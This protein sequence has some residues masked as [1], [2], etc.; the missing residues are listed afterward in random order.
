[1]VAINVAVWLALRMTAAP[2][3]PPARAD[4]ARDV[5]PILEQR[6]Q[7]CHFAGGKMYAHLPFD[8]AATIDKLGTKLFTR[9]KRENEQRIIQ[10]FLTRRRS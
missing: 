8:Q 2:A 9:I 4:F 5:R 1:M 7:P 6:C 10:A 3:P